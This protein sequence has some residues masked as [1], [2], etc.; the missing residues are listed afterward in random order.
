MGMLAQQRRLRGLAGGAISSLAPWLGLAV[1]VIRLRSKSLAWRRSVRS[2]LPLV[3]STFSFRRWDAN[4]A[5]RCLQ[6][7]TSS[8]SALSSQ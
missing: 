2:L 6:D 5:F 7:E 4:P 3:V 1:I 8:S